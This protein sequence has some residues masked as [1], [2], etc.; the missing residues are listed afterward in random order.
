MTK[1]TLQYLAVSF[2]SVAAC[3]LLISTGLK[4]LAPVA[5]LLFVWGIAFSIAAAVEWVR[6]P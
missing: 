4:P 2:A 1:S 6:R 5:L 3:S